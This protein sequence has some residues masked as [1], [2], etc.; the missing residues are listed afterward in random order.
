[1]TAPPA[2]AA[3]ITL[4]AAGKEVD[5]RKMAAGHFSNRLL[6]G[7]L[8]LRIPVRALLEGGVDLLPDPV[9]G[10]FGLTSLFGRRSSS[11]GCDCSRFSNT[12][13]GQNEQYG[14]ESQ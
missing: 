5:V 4:F 7:R 10:L 6:T 11:G 13:T 1:V 8:G 2:Q 9:F 3:K 14:H 12:T